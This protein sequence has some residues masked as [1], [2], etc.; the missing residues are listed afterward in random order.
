MTHPKIYYRPKTLIE[1]I[2]RAAQPNSVALAGGALAFGALEL[3]YEAVVDLQDLE[4]LQQIEIVSTT[5]RIG[6]A[7]TLSELVESPIVPFTLKQSLTR[8]IPPNLR[9][10]TSIGETLMVSNT[11]V[12]RE[13]LAML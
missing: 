9:N 7:V 8:A 3:P 6:G 2:E 11:S 10:N 1:A 4:E 13:W 12:L 5:L